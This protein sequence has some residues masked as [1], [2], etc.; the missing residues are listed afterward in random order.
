MAKSL[1]RFGGT[2]DWR[3][4]TQPRKTP[5]RERFGENGIYVFESR[6][7]DDFRMR[8]TRRPFHKLCVITKGSGWVETAKGRAAFEENHILFIPAGLAHRFVDRQGDPLTLMMA[9]FYGSTLSALPP[10]AATLAAFQQ[11]YPAATPVLLA[12]RNLRAEIARTFR[13]MLFEQIQNHPGAPLRI[14]CGLADL[15][16]AMLRGQAAVRREPGSDTHAGVDATVTWLE[17]HFVDSVSVDDL[18]RSVGLSYRRFTEHFKRATGQTVVEFV[19]RRRVEY[20][21]RLMVESGNI[22]DALY[23]AGFG[24][25]THFYRTFRRYMGVTPKSHI[26]AYSNRIFT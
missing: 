15:L 20:A 4:R 19:T 6:H 22:L 14:W 8:M 1:G 9:S 24:D 10:A 23:A 16:V 13:A 12:H 7:D 2:G 26:A 3:I 17:S 25:V 18:A 11:A 21:A 5:H